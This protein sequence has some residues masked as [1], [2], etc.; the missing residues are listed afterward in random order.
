MLP[1]VIP[2]NR[3]GWPKAFERFRRSPVRL[4]DDADPEPLR[5]QQAAN[6][7]HA[8]AGMID[9]GIAGDDDDVA[10]I[11]ASASISAR[12]IG[13]KGATPKRAA[14]YLRRENSGGAANMHEQVQVTMVISAIR[15]MFQDCLWSEQGNWEQN[16]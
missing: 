13:R 1:A 4:G 3:L 7:R 5:F 12:D 11:P 8:E 6:D 15:R 16:Q 10:G 9:V 14:Q 2:K